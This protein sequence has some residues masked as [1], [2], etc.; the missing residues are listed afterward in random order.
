MS[1]IRTPAL[2]VVV[3][4]A[5]P[6]AVG[7]LERFAAN[8]AALIVDGSV[9]DAPVAVHLVDP[10]PAG[11]GR[12]W[13]FDQSPLLKLNSMAADVTMFTD[14]SCRI[15]GPVQSGPSLIEWAEQVR[16]GVIA[17][18]TVSDPVVADELASL[19]RESF[20]TRR[21]QSVYLEWFYRRAVAALGD[22]VTVSVHADRAVLVQGD[23]DSG[24]RV[25]LGGGDVIDA[26]I[27]LYAVGH[28]GSRPDGATTRLSEFAGRHGLDY[29]PP[30]F[31]ADADTSALTPGRTVI[32]RGFGLAAVDLIVLLT[33]GRGGRFTTRADGSLRYT[34][35][36]REPR[37]VIGSRRGVPYHSKIASSLVGDRPALR[38]FTAEIA[39][40]LVRESPRIDFRADVWPLIAKEM[41]HGYYAELFTGHPGCVQKSWPEFLSAFET[42][43]PFGPDLAQLVEA[44]IPDPD[45]RLDLARFDRPLDGVR[46][47]SPEALQEEV[48][49]YIRRDLRL[50]T[51]PEHSATLGLFTS[52][53]FSLFALST[54]IDAPNWSARSRM[55]DL[56]GWW[57][58]YFSYVASGP[59]GHRLEELL[60]LSEAGVVEF[61]GSEIVVDTDEAEGVFR[62]HGANTD[63]AVT[64]TALVDAWLPPSRASLSDS[65]VLRSLIESGHGSE[66]VVADDDYTGNTGLLTVR[67]EDARVVDASGSPHP[68]RYAIG[69]YTTV[70]FA[71]AFSRP[72]TNAIAFRE[73]DASARAILRQLSELA[74]LAQLAELGA[75]LEEVAEAR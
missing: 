39:A 15:D 65:A 28:N 57:P 73:N 59:P 46:A 10:F 50:R 38:F 64:A 48:R 31:T 70:P 61:L 45:D 34:P 18:V 69:P 44:T 2:S 52:L 23:G 22:D 67:P 33:E 36:G 8:R 11:G 25:V 21:L 24:Q 51:L 29:L 27:V 55:R 47:D 49:A 43:D 40:R 68:R 53:L 30:S 17:D 60:A 14:A 35:S 6:R 1:P 62:A 37:L 32:V 63:H 75:E 19:A 12:I 3:I 74:E 72:G 20:P 58:G 71:G 5:G 56:Q 7:W 42:L 66:Q 16:S 41:L 54:V 26:D 4:G 9:V 13:R